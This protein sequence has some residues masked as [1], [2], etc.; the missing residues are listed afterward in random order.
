VSQ[1]VND[2]RHTLPPDVAYRLLQA[3]R[4]SGLTQQQLADRVA[5][6]RR[7]IGRLEDGTR[8]PSVAVAVRVAL[9][10][11][12]SDGDRNLLLGHAVL[13][14]ESSPHRTGAWS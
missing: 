2:Q 9:T 7:T 4:R 3:R 13:A 10:L 6:S 12:L 8:A 5:V 11:R 14:G 1:F